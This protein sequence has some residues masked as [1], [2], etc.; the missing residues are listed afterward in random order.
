MDQR[1]WAELAQ[2]AVWYYEERL[3]QAEIGQRIGKSRSMV[4]RLLNEVRK[5]NLVEI[6]VNYPLVRSKAL[7]RRLI[8]EFGVEDA[9]VLAN[10][11]KGEAVLTAR[12]VGRLGGLCLQR[13]LEDGI[14]IGLAWSQTL[15]HL[16][17][18]FP[19]TEL[20]DGAVIQLSG[21]IS[22]ANPSFD[23]PELVRQLAT[24]LGATYRYFPAPLIVRDGAV[25]QALVEEP[26]L[27]DTMAVA[28]SVDVARS[29][30]QSSLLHLLRMGDSLFVALSVSL[31]YI[32]RRVLKRLPELRLNAF[33]RHLL[34]QYR[35]RL[36]RQLRDRLQVRKD[37]EPREPFCANNS[38]PLVHNH[39]SVGFSSPGGPGHT[40][41][42]R[43][44][45]FAQF[46]NPAV[47]STGLEQRQSELKN[48]H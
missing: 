5:N 21:S 43:R 6:R 33:Y 4:S 31:F 42:G 10:P 9:Y 29:L 39:Y 14:R 35:Q 20:R 7:E 25:R 12:M 3:S 45:L 17:V 47:E 27:S 23:G 2:I 18:Q 8:T 32:A 36:S 40:Y 38:S 13:K 22:L 28:R 34:V 11:P 46:N 16:V 41:A 37:R 30:R 15:Q 1:R 26:S 19:H 48:P 44:P 24:K